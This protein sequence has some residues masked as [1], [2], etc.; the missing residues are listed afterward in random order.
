[1]SARE[2][3][4][5]LAMFHNRKAILFFVVLS[6]LAAILGC[7]LFG[8]QAEEGEPVSEVPTATPTELPAFPAD[9]VTVSEPGGAEVSVAAGA[10]SGAAE[11]AVEDV[12]EGESFAGGSPLSAASAEYFVD[13]GDAQQIGEI[14]M[15]VPFEGEAKDAA[16]NGS[17][18]YLVWTEPVGGTPSVVGARPVEDKL[19][20]PVVGAGKYQVFKLL[21]HE[22][23]MQLVSI[24][25]PLA[26]PTYQQRTP[27]WCSPTAMTNV[28]N[29]HVGGWPVGGF[30]AV[31][32]ESSNYYLAGKAGQPFD[33]GYFFHWLLGAGGYTVP[34]DV[35]QSFSNGNAEVI[36]WNWKAAVWVDF[37]IFTGVEVYT[38]YA[39]ADLLFNAFQ[40]YVESFVWG[41]NGDRRP[42]AWGSSLA[43]HSRTIT[44]SNG[45][46]YYY[47]DPGSGTLNTSKTW[48]AYRQEVMDSFTGPKI[49][50]IDTVI[51]Y[52]EP[53]P[54]NAR[55][56]VIWL[57]PRKDDGF[58]GSVTLIDGETG[59]P[60]TNWHWDGSNGHE[61]GYYH[62]DLRGVLPTDPLFES[63][64]KALNYQDAVEYGFG[65][66]NIG[67]I[68]YDF[69][70]DVILQNENFSVLENVGKFDA[71]VSPGTREEFNPASNFSLYDKPPGLY[72]IKYVLLQ[73]GVYQDVKY[74]QF[75][76]AETDLLV[77][78]PHVFLTQNAFCRKGPDT[79]FV[80]VTA[81]VAGTDLELVGVNA[82]RT[83]GLVQNTMNEITFQCW[84]ALGTNEVEGEDLVPVM[85]S[86]VLEIEEPEG[87]VC[88]STLGREECEAAGGTYIL[89]AAG[90][91]CICPE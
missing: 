9:T 59:M 36:I 6:L 28:V 78:F 12:G 42:V 86:P 53:R 70:V 55:R 91:S 37:D 47:N 67:T 21:N 32:G 25:D 71:I 88:T 85:M 31:W 64:F 72:T 38:N 3:A 39:F 2:R 23:L 69:H 52:A 82:E 13:L 43:G 44:G 34:S 68:P 17:Y 22:A 29:Y 76:L 27:A 65:I 18:A 66:F 58:P 41:V 26:V 87:P 46:E 60:A 40:A 61:R 50:V 24:Y 11:V 8:E 35:K 57:Y 20:F 7:S 80:D 84:V 45:T 83:W 63:Q 30:G 15:T 16:V 90:V 77:I 1:M 33:Q 19:Q 56:G 48:A 79:R 74:V 14:L 75:R 89:G 73:N 81:F 51:F 4:R 10:L 54:A 5:R 62:E 49:E